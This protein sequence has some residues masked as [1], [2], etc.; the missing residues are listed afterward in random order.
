MFACDNDKAVQAFLM[1]Q[2]PEC[3]A[4]ITDAKHLSNDWAPT[5]HG[6]ASKLLKVEGG[7]LFIAGFV[8]KTRCKLNPKRNTNLQCVQ[9]GEE[10]T[11][12][13]WQHVSGYIKKHVPKAFILENVY[14]LQDSEDGTQSDC[15]FIIAWATELNYVCRAFRVDAR[16]YGSLP[17]R[18]RLYWIGFYN[19][20]QDQFMLCLDFMSCEL[21][22]GYWHKSCGDGFLIR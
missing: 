22:G 4:L 21:R 10:K 7:D 2:F 17:R 5:V 12:E 14:E 15:D 9:A 13:S 16:L 8:C 6:V 3:E 20:T 11:G 18:D 1:D 19:G